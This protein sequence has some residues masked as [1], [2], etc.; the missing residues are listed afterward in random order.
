MWFL[1]IDKLLIIT[2]VTLF[3][4]FLRLSNAK[5]GTKIPVDYIL[6]IVEI[7][8]IFYISK[9]LAVFYLIY[10]IITYLLS[11]VL[12]KSSRYKKLLFPIFCLVAS[13]PFFI[14]RL[15]DLGIVFDNL[16]IIIGI[17]YSVFKV[18]DTYYHVYYS[19]EPINPLIYINYILFLP[20]FTAGPIHRYRE[21]KKSM[22]NPIL[23]D[24]EVVSYSVGRIIKGL[25]KKLVVTEIL[26]I[27]FN[28]LQT[29]NLR[30]Y[31]SL[32]MIVMSYAVLFFDF[33][34]Y[35]DIAIAFGALAGIS[36][37]E[38][39]KKPWAAPTMTQFWRNWHVTLSDFIRDHIHV[40][41]VKKRFTK[42]QGGIIGFFTMVTMALWHG[43]N[44]PYVIAGVYLGMILFFES[45]FSLTTLNRRTTNKI[46][47]A[48]R[49]LL[50]NFL[51]GLNTLVFT[52]PK[53]K[54]VKVI[55]GLFNI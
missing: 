39:F 46:Y 40:V 36:V 41:I 42:I 31:I 38:N 5:L 1:E 10:I 53:D 15:T 28:H 34:G 51:F 30:W 32:L 45:I 49:C 20:V 8:V 25:F 2:V 6:S 18:I 22:E 33:S 16:F 27:E 47:F 19:G 24:M 14:N 9:R 52:L 26:F 50:T 37:P 23:L 21:F 11:M 7:G 17:S 12:L 3:T 44:V 4:G 54:V 35:S 43:F 55:L 48:F 13:S 29:L